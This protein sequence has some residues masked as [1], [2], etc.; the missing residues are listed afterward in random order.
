[1]KQVNNFVFQQRVEQMLSQNTYV[2]LQKAKTENDVLY[3]MKI[4]SDL[5]KTKVVI[6]N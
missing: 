1:M 4:L 5:G 3:I 6:D 2:R